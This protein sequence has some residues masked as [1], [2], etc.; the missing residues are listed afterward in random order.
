MSS[1][2]RDQSAQPKRPRKLLYTT[3][4]ARRKSRRTSNKLVTRV[5]KT[6]IWMARTE[7]RNR[8]EKTARKTKI[9]KQE[10]ITR[11]KLKDKLKTLNQTV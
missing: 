5:L 2:S 11:F 3:D 10:Q 9:Q 7:T 6:A 4:Y 8:R 1:R